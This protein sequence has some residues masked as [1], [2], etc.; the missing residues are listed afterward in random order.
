MDDSDTLAIRQKL[1]ENDKIEAIFVLPR[2]MFYSTDISV[3]LWILNNNKKGGPWHNRQLRN[4][5]GEILFV[6]L[7][8]WNTNIYEKKFVRFTD[9][10]IA[11]ICKV[12]FDWQTQK[13]DKYAKPELYY[14]AHFDEIKEKNFSLVPSRYIE[15]VDRD[16]ELDY[17]TALKTAGATVKELLQRQ[18]EN[19]TAL[20]NAFKTIGYDAE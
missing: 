1:V 4:R 8:T 7:R 14:A 12:Y 5:S 9:E 17:A 20:I 11:D 13:T 16:T 10:Q 15:F 3:T 18:E 6:D 19:R 2:E